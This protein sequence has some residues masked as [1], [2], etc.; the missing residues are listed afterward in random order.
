M[1]VLFISAVFP[2]PLHSGGQIRIYNLL[3]QLS[4]RHEIT[5]V[6]FIR[7]A[8]EAN[9]GSALPFI[10][11][12]KT[13]LRGHVW[14]CQYL[15]SALVGSYPLLL[16][17]Y[18]NEAMRRAV[19]EELGQGDYDLIHLEPGYVWPSVPVTQLP[20]VIAEHNIE[21]TV[22][23]G[24]AQKFFFRPLVPLLNF[25]VRKLKH[26]E[27]RIWRQA[28]QITT[29]SPEDAQIVKNT[30]PEARVTVVPNGV[31]IINFVFH[32]KA[33]LNL[34]KLKFLFVGNFT[35]L[36]N[37]DAVSYLLKDWWPQ[38]KQQFEGSKLTIVGPALPNN[39][40]ELANQPTVTLAGEISDIRRVYREAD[41]MLA[42]LRI[43]G[44][45][46][47]KV[48]EAMAVGLPVVTTAVGAM[49]FE[50]EQGKHLWLAETS[51]QAVGAIEKIVKETTGREM[52]LKAGR[53][54]IQKKYNWQ[55]IADRL[56]G[57]WQRAYEQKT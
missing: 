45:T 50:M 10:K 5:L 27:K 56:N 44:G 13:A 40:R 55:G 51:L 11:R 32:P 30:I 33:K 49:G 19:G 39:L 52:I 47:F 12:I 14:Q 4:Q 21:S 9:L 37:R 23:A 2:Y 1:K 20:V 26:W 25:D 43:G 3:K 8:R 28:N 36:Q 15:W 42:P 6:S 46:K 57:V 29:V 53:E 35:W 18:D 16:A 48:L 34:N 7:Q 31:D 17:S 38:I 54:L 41:I 22:Y 24:F